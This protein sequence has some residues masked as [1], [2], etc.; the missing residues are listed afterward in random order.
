MKKYKRKFSYSLQAINIV[1]LLIFGIVIIIFDVHTFTQAMHKEVEIELH[2][3]AHNVITLFD[4][5]YPGDYELIGETAY[6]LY[7]G[8]TDITG[9]YSLI[10]KVKEDTGMEVTLF[11][12]D[13][14]ML[15][16]ICDAEGERITGSIAP[17]VV[18]QDLLDTGEPHFYS[19]IMIYGFSYFGYYAP[20]FHSDGNVI[21][22]MFVGKRSD[23]VNASI[24]D[25]VFPIIIVGVVLMA[26]TGIFTF[27]YTKSITSVLSKIH[28]FLSKVSTGDLS[29]ELSNKVLQ[30]NDE[31]GEIGH[32]AMH[33]QHSLRTLVEQ[34]ML[35]GL[36]NRRAGEARLCRTIGQS[37]KRGV[38]YSVA[39]GDIDYFKNVNDTYGHECG[40]VVLKNVADLLKKHMDKQGYAIR[41][42]GEEFLLV[43][44]NAESSV[45]YSHLLK[46]LDDIRNHVMTYEGQVIRVTLT[47]GLA[48]GNTDAMEQLVKE[49]D[50]KLY[51]G[52]TS[53][54]NC[55]I[56]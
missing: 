37:Q 13:A 6:R 20:L 41:W 19:H 18:M 42:G 2:N 46:L 52:K 43:Y 51:K 3:V 32:S 36:Y 23:T 16:T 30:R 45:A 55:I 29:T 1:P 49:A 26:C 8:G 22:I 34:D 47:F 38:S 17:F 56:T 50:N 54:R 15:T 21:G 27:F 4:V 12:Q 31:L 25:S 28:V 33:M 35:T 14:R 11:Y 9:E 5:A 48:E 53:G 40:D 7:K 39:I 44:E 24:F 10:D